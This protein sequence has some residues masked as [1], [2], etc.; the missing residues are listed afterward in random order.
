MLNVLHN[1]SKLCASEVNKIKLISY[2]FTEGDER[3]SSHFRL[4]LIGALLNR[5]KLKERLSGIILFSRRASGWTVARQARHS[6]R[7]WK[8]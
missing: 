8:L 6:D 5:T 1:T 3:L 2:E 4:A 7:D